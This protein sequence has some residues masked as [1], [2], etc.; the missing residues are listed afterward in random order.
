[1][2]G[3]FTVKDRATN[4]VSSTSFTNKQ[5][6]KMVRDSLNTE[7]GWSSVIYE[8]TPNEEPNKV[9]SP[10]YVAKGPDHWLYSN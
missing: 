4:K 9:P 2:K 3:L 5:D 7:A 8:G 1:M 6:A 10:F